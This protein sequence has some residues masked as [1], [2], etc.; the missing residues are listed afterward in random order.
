MEGREVLWVR[1]GREKECWRMISSIDL[2]CDFGGSGGGGGDEPIFEGL[3]PAPDSESTDSPLESIGDDT[4]GL[5]IPSV[6]YAL[7]ISS[8]LG[9]TSPTPSSTAPLPG[10]LSTLRVVVGSRSIITACGPSSSM[11]A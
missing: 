8:I 2:M 6:V 5:R 10:L 1:T 4:E 3:C 9:A 7:M 11:L